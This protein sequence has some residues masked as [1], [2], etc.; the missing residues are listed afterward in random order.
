MRNDKF[1]KENNGYIY[2]VIGVFFDTSSEFLSG[3][4]QW[5]I[6]IIDEMFES[7]NWN[8]TDKDPKVEE[9]KIGTFL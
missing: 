6:N 7:M 9:V 4:E 1:S 5:E 2:A 3:F 8:V